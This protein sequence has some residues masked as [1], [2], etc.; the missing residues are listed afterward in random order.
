MQHLIPLVFRTSAPPLGTL[1]LIKI[2]AGSLPWTTRTR[3][4]AWTDSTTPIYGYFGNSD[5][6]VPSITRDLARFGGDAG[7]PTFDL[8]VGGFGAGLSPWFECPTGGVGLI[9]MY[10]SGDC[11]GYLL[12]EPI[13][14]CHCDK[15]D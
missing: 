15:G 3:V 4:R 2:S 7:G 13:P 5:L 6:D 14:E 8:A 11:R 10:A 1:G 9:V 12:F